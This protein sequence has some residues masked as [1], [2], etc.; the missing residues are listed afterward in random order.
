MRSLKAPLKDYLR[1]RTLRRSGIAL[2]VSLPTWSAGAR[3]GVWVV[4][5]G[6][7]GPDSLVYS[8]GVGDNIAWDLALIERFSLCLHAF[9]P[10]PRSV[11]WI[12]EQD[13]P[14][15]FHFHPIGLAAQ[16]GQQSFCA[17][18]K[19]TSANYRPVREAGEV[20]GEV[21]TLQTIARDLG[22]KRIDVLKIDVEGGEYALMESVLTSGV[23][24]GQLLI[25]FHHDQPK[26]SFAE[27][28]H[29]IDQIRAAGF[30][31]LHISDRGLEMTFVHEQL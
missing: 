16:D 26:R 27:T 8:V 14:A 10:T 17:P 23:P 7:L 29:A 3:S 2:E 15:R 22:H 25:E 1:R 11:A 31:L 21:R 4:C 18:R 28:A 9:D 6:P 30:R 20:Q 13:L 5:P 24:I 19:A 12:A